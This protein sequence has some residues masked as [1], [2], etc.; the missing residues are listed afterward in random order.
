MT[1]RL[2]KQT[3]V[4]ATTMPI[5]AP[6]HVTVLVAKTSSSMAMAPI[7]LVPRTSLALKKPTTP[8]DANAAVVSTERI[9]ACAFWL[10]TRAP[11]SSL[12]YLQPE[13]IG[14]HKG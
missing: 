7:A 5:T 8:V 3:W 4:S 1:Q 14:Q 9:F 10:K 6:Q 12:W 2:K 11:Y 13:K